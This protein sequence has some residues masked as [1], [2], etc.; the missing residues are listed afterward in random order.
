[1][2]I[3]ILEFIGLALV[4]AIAGTFLARAA[5]QIADVTGLG[6]LLVGSLLL[7]AA[8]SLPEL[9]VSI[10]AVRRGM[11][12]LAVGDL[13]G[14][15][16]VNLLVLAVLDL[17]HTKGGKMLSRKAAAHALSATLAITLAALAAIGILASRH[18]EPITWLGVGTTSWLILLA[19]A[20]GARMVFINQR[21]AVRAA[22]E[23]TTA[24][25]DRL[26]ERTTPR[27]RLRDRLFAPL[28][29]F[30]IAAAM[31]FLTG[32]QL[33]RAAGELA[34][35]TG[36]SET[37][38]GTAL[39]ALCTTLPEIVTSIAAIQ[40][41]AFD[42][43][44]GNVFG[45]SAFNILLLVPVDAAHPGSLLHDVSPL[46]A[47]TALGVI[48][49]TAIALLGQLY[50]VEHRIRFIDPDALLVIIAVVS[51]LSLVYRLSHLTG[52]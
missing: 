34:E 10:A 32:P 45:S 46:H 15:S 48:V 49:A 52:H 44:I 11:P 13:L 41:G 33:A 30:A 51:A 27:H 19:Y 31:I 43:V 20:M 26:P 17:V 25:D 8:T 39:L 7:A 35:R 14:A 23:T 16:L 18:L 12:D 40:L 5:D 24:S 28:L 2:T 4:V 50:D 42:L 37:F 36:L 1:M 29:T 38:V 9:T 6:R 3:L 47:V 22:R 21:I